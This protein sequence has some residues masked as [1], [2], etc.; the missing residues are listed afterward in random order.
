MHVS[1]LSTLYNLLQKTQ[2]GLEPKLKS[3]ATSAISRFSVMLNSL[4]RRVAIKKFYMFE[5]TTAEILCG[6]YFERLVDPS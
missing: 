5:T 2:F 1:V 4:A 3:M 6:M